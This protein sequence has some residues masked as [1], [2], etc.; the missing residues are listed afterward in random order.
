MSWKKLAL[1][2]ASCS[3]A[4]RGSRLCLMKPPAR[5]MVALNSRNS[6]R[7]LHGPSRQL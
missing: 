5:M 4:P 3:N 2:A 1:V 6:W 7:S